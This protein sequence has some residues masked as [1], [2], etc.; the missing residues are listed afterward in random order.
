MGGGMMPNQVPCCHSVRFVGSVARHAARM[1]AMVALAVLVA[2]G[3]PGPS[4]G[5]PDEAKAMAEHAAV[6]L[7]DVGP[8]K[9]IAD[10]NDPQGEFHDRNLFVVTYNGQRRIVSSLGVPAYLGRDATGF[11]D[12]DGKEF[13]KAIIGMAETAG[14]G[15]VSYRMTN[16]ATMKVELKR[17]YVVKA[18][19]YIVF[20]G[21]YEP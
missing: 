6:H 13:G 4:Q 2:A 20:V 10:F 9:A 7:R 17:S 11:V 1:A 16:P 12:A 14:A 15:W 19:D 18:G 5:T 21:A 8:E 3:S